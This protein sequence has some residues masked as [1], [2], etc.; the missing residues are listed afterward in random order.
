MISFCPPDFVAWLLCGPGVGSLCGPTARER[1]PWRPCVCVVVR[2]GNILKS[3]SFAGDSPIQDS[4]QIAFHKIFE[5]DNKGSLH[6]LGRT[7]LPVGYAGNGIDRR[8][9]V[10]HNAVFRICQDVATE[11]GV[12][13][14]KTK[15]KVVIKALEDQTWLNGHFFQ[16][17]CMEWWG[18]TQGRGAG[19]RATCNSRQSGQ[20]AVSKT[21]L[22]LSCTAS[23]WVML[24]YG[25]DGIL[26]VAATVL[27]A[28][29]VEAACRT[30]HDFK[31]TCKRALKEI[32]AAKESFLEIGG[33]TSSSSSW[34]DRMHQVVRIVGCEMVEWVKT[35]AIRGILGSG[36]KAVRDWKRED[37]K[38]GALRLWARLKSPHLW[39]VY[40][41]S[42]LPFLKFLIKSRGDILMKLM[43]ETIEGQDIKAVL[44]QRINYD[45]REIVALLSAVLTFQV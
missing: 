21:L 32:E 29:A 9:Y 33:S 45:A 38:Q 20:T 8:F 22:I 34:G 14:A 39:G 12:K 43:D 4:R 10:C 16:V 26:Q 17:D 2:Q 5:G 30:Q 42:R 7:I 41:G 35:G 25:G 6:V 11:C 40:S 13:L 36:K 3:A 18:I 28:G 27:D 15:K 1:Q 19:T 44:L 37:Q 24:R 31:M 23:R